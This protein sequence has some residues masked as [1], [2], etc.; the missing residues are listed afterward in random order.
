MNKEDEEE[1]FLFKFV[2]VVVVVF[3]LPATNVKVLL[4]NSLA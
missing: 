1:D 2:V 3:F 4:G